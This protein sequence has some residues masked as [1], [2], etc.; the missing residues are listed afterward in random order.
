MFIFVDCGCI[1]VVGFIY[2]YLY[3]DGLPCTW[4]KMYTA[5]ICKWESYHSI[6]NFI[7]YLGYYSNTL[8]FY[9]NEHQRV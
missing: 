5:C 8:I 1:C 9:M 2:E 7:N 4:C 6:N 3:I